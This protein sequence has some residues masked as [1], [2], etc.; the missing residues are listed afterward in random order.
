MKPILRWHRASEPGEYEGVD[1]DGSVAATIWRTTHR[2]AYSV[3]VMDGPQPTNGVWH[4]H[5]V[6]GVAETLADAKAKAVALI[7]A[8]VTIVVGNPRIMQ[9]VV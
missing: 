4:S 7:A 5:D 2:W 3:T 1:R 6:L 9:E 8:E